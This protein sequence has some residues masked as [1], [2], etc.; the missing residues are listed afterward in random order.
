M[1]HFFAAIRIDALQPLDR[2]RAAMDAM[3]DA[4]HA[5]P[6]ANS[7]DA[8]CYPGQIEFAT[9]IERSKH[10]IPINDRLCDEL[11]GL[12]ERLGLE[13]PQS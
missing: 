6:T 5:A 3:I 7:I 8:V 4:L 2:F 1:G 10:G 9:A 11:Q 13:L 12:A